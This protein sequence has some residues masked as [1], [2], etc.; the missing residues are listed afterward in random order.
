MNM[1]KILNT[2]MVVTTLFWWNNAMSIDEEQ[3][4]HEDILTEIATNRCNSE[5][6]EGK[7]YSIKVLGDGKLEI[8]LLGTKGGEIKGSF[9]VNKNQW[10]GRQRVLPDDQ[11]KATELFV[12]CKQE[13]LKF[14]RDSYKPPLSQ[15][16]IHRLNIETCIAEKIKNFESTQQRTTNGGARTNSRKPGN[17][18]PRSSVLLCFSVGQNQTITSAYTEETCCHGGRCSVTAPE[19]KNEYKEVCVTTSCWSDSAYF[20]GGG[21][22]KYN[23][24][25]SY[26][27]IATNKDKENFKGEC[28]SARN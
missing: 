19:Y 20:G 23:L 5:F 24:I 17:S 2:I 8:S 10:E 27:N 4:K 12:K 9:I 21:C 3:K 22:G 25:T 14:L 16:D 7:D 6:I 15:S 18:V 11:Q 1:R 13:E 26:K 28:E